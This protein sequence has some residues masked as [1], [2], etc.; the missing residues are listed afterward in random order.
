MITLEYSSIFTALRVAKSLYK[1]DHYVVVMI[2][3]DNYAIKIWMNG[4]EL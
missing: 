3:T 2:K 1:T 4:V